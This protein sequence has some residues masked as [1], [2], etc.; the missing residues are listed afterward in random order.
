LSELEAAAQEI[1]FPVIVKAVDSSGSRGITKVDEYTELA[2]AYSE[3]LKV[4]NEKHVIVEE[5]LLGYELGAQAVVIGNKV[6][7]VLLHSDEVTPPPISVPIGHAMP[8]NIEP[9]LELKIR[10]LVIK[11]VSALG[12]MDTISNVDIMV[13]D[14]EPYLLEIG[15]RMGATCIPENVSMFIGGDIYEFLINL[16]LGR[17]PELPRGNF[18]QPNAAIILRSDQTGKVKR[19]QLPENIYE[20]P[21]LVEF[22]IDIAEGDQVKRFTV[23]PDRIGQV[24]VKAETAEEAISLTKYFESMLKI[25]IE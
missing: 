20:H 19:I 12:I 14:G 5:Y 9:E 2:R 23:G 21:N 6:S 22:R 25:E 15:A 24:I 18:E 16:A 3:A 13:V 4:S 10:E 7:D 11:A 1:G 8:L 17:K